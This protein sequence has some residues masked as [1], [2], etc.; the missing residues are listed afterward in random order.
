MMAG[1]QW[2]NDEEAGMEESASERIAALEAALREL[3]EAAWVYEAVQDAATHP[4]RGMV[5]PI[6]VAQGIALQDALKKADDAL[7]GK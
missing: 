7:E 1:N 5:Q 6:T 3:S 2:Q 4:S